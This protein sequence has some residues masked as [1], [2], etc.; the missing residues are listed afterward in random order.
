MTIFNLV[1]RQQ[2]IN[3]LPKESQQPVILKTS[4]SSTALMYLSLDSK[5][6]TPQQITD[7]ATRVVQPQLQTVDGVAKVDILGGSTYSMRIFLDSIKMAALNIS[8]DTL[9]YNIIFFQFS[10]IFMC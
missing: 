10:L 7:Y 3:Q 9:L 2:T 1:L 5:K 6:M 8:L 4:D